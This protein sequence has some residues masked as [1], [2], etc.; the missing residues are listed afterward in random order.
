[1]SRKRHDAAFKAKVAAEALKG[2]KSLS[3]LSAW[4]PFAVRARS[5]F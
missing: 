3:E 4:T 1:M 5:G 2:I